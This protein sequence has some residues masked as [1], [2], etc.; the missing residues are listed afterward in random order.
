MD[1][2]AVNEMVG[3]YPAPPMLVTMVMTMADEAPTSAPT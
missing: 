2:G 1:R 3:A